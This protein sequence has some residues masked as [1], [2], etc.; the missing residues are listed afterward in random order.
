MIA[1]SPGRV[2]IKV[3]GQ[4]TITHSP[5]DYR[6]KPLGYDAQNDEIHDNITRMRREKREGLK[7]LRQFACVI[8]VLQHS[9]TNKYFW[10]RRITVRCYENCRC[11]RRRTP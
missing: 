8:V 3:V 10:L 7:A 2:F 5:K 4:W 11:A 1:P 9:P 6:F